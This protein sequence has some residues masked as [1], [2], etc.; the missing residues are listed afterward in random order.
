MKNGNIKINGYYDE[1]GSFNDSVLFV[2]NDNKYNFMDT[3]GNLLSKDWFDYVSYFYGNISEVELNGKSNLFSMDGGLLFDEWMF[4]IDDLT[5]VGIAKIT[6]NDAKV[7]Y[8]RT[9][10]SLLCDTWFDSGSMFRGNVAIVTMEDDDFEIHRNFLTTNGEIKYPS[11]W[12]DRISLPKVGV[13]KKIKNV[14]Y[15]LKLGDKIYYADK[16]GNVN[17]DYYE[18]DL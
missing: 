17:F 14:V 9:D 15:K 10:G 6:N 4:F 12:F 11:I 18:S 3:N 5:E 2:K 1:I 13:S 7:N 16:D 8:V